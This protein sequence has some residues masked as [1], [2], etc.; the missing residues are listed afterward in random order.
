MCRSSSKDNYNNIAKQSGVSTRKSESCHQFFGK[1]ET[2]ILDT[3]QRFGEIFVFVNWVAI[4]NKVQN[5]GIYC[6]W[7]V[8]ADNHA[9][10]SFWL[11]N[12]ETKQ[13]VNSRDVIA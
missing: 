3:V 5:Y 1:G 4:M 6:F 11:L 10:K 12:P 2:N 13:I 9:S 8:F 7:L